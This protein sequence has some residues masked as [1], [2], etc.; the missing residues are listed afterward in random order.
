MYRKLAQSIITA[1]HDVKDLRELMED[2]FSRDILEH[3][4][5][6]RTQKGSKSIKPLRISDDPHWYEKKS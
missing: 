5:Q 3:A 4:K 2:D 6:S 1:N